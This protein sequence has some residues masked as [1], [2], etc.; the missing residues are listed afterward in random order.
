MTRGG[1]GEAGSAVEVQIKVDSGHDHQ[2]H[3]PVQ[4]AVEGEVGLLGVD[5]A[6]FGVVHADSQQVFLLVQLIGDVGAE[7]G[8]TTLMIHHLLTVD[9]HG[10]SVGGSGDLQIH[11]V[12]GLGLGT[13]QFLGVPAGA[14][15]VV[16]AAVLAV[17]SVPGVGQIHRL[18]VQGQL[19]GQAGIL[20]DEQP[21][22]IDIPNSA[23]VFPLL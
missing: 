18:P 8:E 14:A 9:I 13:G 17:Q 6:L 7:G 15:V 23:H 5:V 22:G 12:A 2:V 1:D 20:T 21:V 11:P 3:I 16:G 4:A 19:G 10:G